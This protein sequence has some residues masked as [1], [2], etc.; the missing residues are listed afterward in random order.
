[1]PTTTILISR[2]LI[3][4][5]RY[6]GVRPTIS[7]ARKAASTTASSRP[8]RPEPIPPNTSSP[9]IMFAIGTADP[10]PVKDS[11]AAFTAPLAPAV[12]LAA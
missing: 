11:I 3:F 9:V 12:V 6:S 5:P 1:M 4:L 8:D 7:P 2:A 10:R